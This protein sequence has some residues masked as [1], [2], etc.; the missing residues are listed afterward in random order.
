MPGEA[1]QYEISLH[2]DIAQAVSITFD[3][4]AMKAPRSW[5]KVIFEMEDDYFNTTSQRT[6]L[7]QLA[8]LSTSTSIPAAAPW[9]GALQAGEL[10]NGS[11]SSAVRTGV[12]GVE[13]RGRG[14][15]LRLLQI[16][17]IEVLAVCDDYEPH[18]DQALT[19]TNGKAKEYRNYPRY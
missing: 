2:A 17:N 7:Q 9:V 18:Y 11:A 3:K 8:V 12:V 6:F 1:E 14:L 15:L 16:S 13:S 4:S 5:Q 10:D 19:I